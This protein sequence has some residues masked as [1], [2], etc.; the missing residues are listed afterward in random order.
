MHPAFSIIIFT[1]L[2]GL[3][4]GLAAILGLG[5]LDPT[6]IATKAAYVLAIAFVGIGLLSSTL[7][8][9]NPQ[10]AWRAFSQW[11]SSWLSR[12]G[13]MAIATFVP[14][15]WSAWAVVVESRYA[16][17]PGIVGACCAAVTVYCTGMIYASLKSI[18]AWHTPLTPVCFLLFA[19]SG[20]LILASLAAAIGGGDPLY[21]AAAAAGATIA[22]WFA[23]TL[24]RRRMLS[25]RSASTPETATGL[26]NIGRVTLFERPHMT[27]N[28]LTREMGFKIA[29]KHASKLAR[30]S[31]ALG[32]AL[33]VL[34]LM[35]AIASLSVAPG[36][37]IASLALAAV[38]HGA[39]LFL[40]RWLFFAEARHAVMNYYGG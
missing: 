2:S 36:L 12:E 11:R 28:Y 8:L 1:T 23:K 14:L 9:G 39:G 3:G 18:D 17:V 25:M 7:H 19:L 35:I 26:G 6:A 34:L 31:F 37:A 13:V 16:M 24:W 30:I 22:A 15:L 27:E 38:T 29:R 32:A 33:T 4:Y 10:R 5:A 40:E 20:G 21:P